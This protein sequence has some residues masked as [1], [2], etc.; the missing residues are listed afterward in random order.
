MFIKNTTIKNFHDQYNFLFK[1]EVQCKT[2]L[3]TVLCDFLDVG[4]ACLSEVGEVSRLGV[5]AV[6]HSVRHDD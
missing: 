6:Y 1:C 2:C 3:L 5:T 4:A